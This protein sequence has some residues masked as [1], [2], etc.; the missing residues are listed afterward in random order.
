MLAP[1]LLWPA[2]YNA[3]PL[4]FADTGTYLDQALRFYAGW[5]R[6]PAYSALIFP[7]HFGVTTWPI[8]IAQAGLMTYLLGLLYRVM[9]PGATWR[10]LAGGIV[11]LAL[12]SA[13]PW[14]ISQIMPDVFTPA[15]VIC[16]G[17]LALAH[18]RLSRGE[19]WFCAIVATIAVAV[20]Y[21]HLML[22]SGL[23]I[24]LLLLRAV[25]LP[26]RRTGGIGWL[27]LPVLLAATGWMAVNTIAHGRPTL[28]PFGSVFLLARV[29]HDGPGL[30]YL[31]NACPQAG[32]R[33]CPHLDA[34][35]GTSD[36]FLW[37]ADSAMHRAGGPKLVAEEAG[38]IVAAAIRAD[39]LKQLAAAGRNSLN[40]FLAFRTG[41]GLE[42]W[43]ATPGPQPV[44]DR[45][46]PAAE[47]AAYQASRQ[48]SGDLFPL[49]RG[50]SPLHVGIA[51]LAMVCCLV[52][53][54]LL[55]RDPAGLFC[56]AVLLA[57]IGNAILAGALSSV[58]DRY[59]AR[60]VWLAVFAAWIAVARWQSLRR[61][62]PWR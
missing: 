9:V 50:L 49:A 28:S 52:F 51:L 62:S 6:P 13:A 41:D 33:L 48:V 47:A 24:C 54:V 3:Y 38:T 19:R 45:Y 7:F 1:L 2:A 34:I 35:T 46:F 29:I 31:R 10:G 53:A 58:H 27:T 18:D 32:Y 55:R 16:L 60:L 40:Q 22:G 14:F 25:F 37:D 26:R 39:P 44:L 57:L 15:L 30:N 36:T 12:G 4:V 8:V 17:L 56:A 42:A 59:Q 11:L 20:H 43:P 21:S 61:V 23:I 5:D